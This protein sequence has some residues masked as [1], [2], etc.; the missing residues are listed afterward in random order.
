MVPTPI[1]PLGLVHFPHVYLPL[2]VFEPRYRQLTVD[3]L[4]GDRQFGVVLIER[5]S[6][7]GGGDTRFDI[8]TM[9]SIVEAG[10]N[11]LGLVRLDTVGVHRI[12]VV[13]WLDDDPYPVAETEE[14]APPRM[15]RPELDAL[16]AVERKV[17]QALAMLAELDERA[18][19]FTIELDDDPARA[20]FQLAAIAP[21]GPMDQQR[22]LST[23]EPLELLGILDGYLDDELGVL[24]SR[25]SGN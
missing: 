11:E 13:R 3:C 4:E 16:S 21:I 14:L 24:A 6:E 15:G 20:L 17:R 9:T 12:R 1:F 23:V 18:T 5:G 10:F 22:L 2:Q 25:L 7:V 19:P 8:G